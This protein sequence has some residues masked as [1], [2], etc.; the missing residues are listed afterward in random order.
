MQ[1]SDISRVHHLPALV[2]KRSEPDVKV[3]RG[4]FHEVKEKRLQGS[5]LLEPSGFTSSHQRVELTLKK[6]IVDFHGA[7]QNK[8]EITRNFGRG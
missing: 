8:G 2:T 1:H 6:K 5:V 4:F 3:P 7:R